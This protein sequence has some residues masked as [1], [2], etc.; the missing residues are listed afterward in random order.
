MLWKHLGG[1]Y[2]AEQLEKADLEGRMNM[3]RCPFCAEKIQDAA[4][5]CKHCG[6]DL[7]SAA[8]A[9]SSA[10]RTAKRPS[11]WVFLLAVVGL[12]VL[13]LMLLIWVG[14]INISNP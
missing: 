9:K 6:R 13:L 1:F 8:I 11:F 3:K 5:V 7:D 14:G 4:I 10:T 2:H 12:G